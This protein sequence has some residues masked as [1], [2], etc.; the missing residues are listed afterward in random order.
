MANTDR[1]RKQRESFPD[2]D[3]LYDENGDIKLLEKVMTKAVESNEDYAATAEEVINEEDKK[4]WVRN[5]GNILL[6]NW[7]NRKDW[8]DKMDVNH[9]FSGNFF[10]KDFSIDSRTSKVADIPT[11][12]IKTDK[13]T[14]ERHLEVS[15][16]NGDTVKTIPLVGHL[17]QLPYVPVRGMSLAAPRIANWVTHD[18]IGN[19]RFKK[20]VFSAENIE[21]SDMNAFMKMRF[22]YTP[23][24]D[25]LFNQQVP[26]SA[27]LME[28]GIT[29]LGILLV[30]GVG[31]S[32]RQDLTK[33]NPFHRAAMKNP[34]QP[35]WYKPL[36]YITYPIKSAV[37]R[38]V[39]A[40]DASKGFYTVHSAA[41]TQT[42][43]AMDASMR[44]QKDP[45]HAQ[46]IQA[47]FMS[48]LKSLRAAFEAQKLP[49]K[50]IDEE[51]ALVVAKMIQ[52]DPKSRY[53]F[54]ETYNGEVAPMCDVTGEY[55]FNMS[56]RDL[57]NRAHGGNDDKIHSIK[58][59][60][61]NNFTLGRVVRDKNDK[62]IFETQN[63][64]DVFDL[65]GERRM[66][67][68]HYAAP[69]MPCIDL[70][71]AQH[72]DK[73]RE[74]ILTKDAKFGEAQNSGDF[75]IRDG[76]TLRHY[77]ELTDGDKSALYQN[78]YTESRIKD[79]AISNLEDKQDDD[80]FNAELN[81]SF[82]ILDTE[83]VK[84]AQ[85]GESLNDIDSA[86]KKMDAYSAP[87]KDMVNAIEFGNLM[88]QRKSVVDQ[89]VKIHGNMGFA[90]GIDEDE[91]KESQQKLTNCLN[92]DPA[93]DP[94]GSASTYVSAVAGLI[95]HYNRAEKAS[96]KNDA[97]KY[98]EMLVT[99]YHNLD[100]MSPLYDEVEGWEKF[101][102]EV[103]NRYEVERPH[104]SSAL[105]PEELR[106]APNAPQVEIP[107]DEGDPYKAEEW[108]RKQGMDD[109]EE[110]DGYIDE[111]ELNIPSDIEDSDIDDWTH[112][113]S[114][115]N[116]EDGY[117]HE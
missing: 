10:T 105:K 58:R 22:I 77:S 17:T 96:D 41:M 113:D 30:P 40:K 52:A 7:K 29:S 8:Y 37:H 47:T 89:M 115:N 73:E 25:A 99:M 86:M 12:N 76:A 53:F 117:E 16:A 28:A 3:K 9:A 21:R 82:R 98:G 78:H 63:G 72:I 36:S 66:V 48:D 26:V 57:R 83:V 104:T 32:V 54:N 116:G 13:V 50:A 49:L 68:E 55:A 64:K 6:T 80:K 31:K 24:K 81:A 88:K 107:E 45:M 35:V 46:S 112:D 2:F 14:G 15:H 79:K 43:L 5:T 27:R 84:Y 20:K 93:S 11:I 23:I 92:G 60:Q 111:N 56:K 108:L 87:Y 102:T 70:T 34:E 97:K 51:Q 91:V 59:L 39:E 85:L 42:A 18:Y 19:V 67:R 33:I 106:L 110:E 69:L 61:N 95:E 38:H 74:R 1:L 103:I 65:T 101:G 94:S 100:S 114:K 109:D 62:V 4:N 71:D 75:Y 90:L 44:M